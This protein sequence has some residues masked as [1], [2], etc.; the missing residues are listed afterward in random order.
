MFINI[1]KNKIHSEV[2]KIAMGLRNSLEVYKSRTYSL[3]SSLKKI[4][5]TTGGNKKDEVQ[6]RALER[7]AKANRILFETFLN[8]FKETTS[9]QG[10]EQADARI[11]SLAEPPLIAS[12]P[13][14]KLLLIKKYF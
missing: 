13:K 1:L 10:M 5:A 6:L 14:K 12:F 8:R 3:A 4:E 9:T 7:E 2:K 11:I